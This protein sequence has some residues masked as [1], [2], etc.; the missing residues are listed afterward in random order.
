[1]GVKTDDK[2]QT[3]V[4]KLTKNEVLMLNI[5]STSTGG[6]VISVRADLA[7]IILTNPACT[8]EGEKIALSRRI[9]NHWRY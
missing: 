5:G 9:D 1:L 8:E 3:K 6:R 2:K 7:K 4:Q